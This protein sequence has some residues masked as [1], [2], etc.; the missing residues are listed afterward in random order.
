MI[1][2]KSILFLLLFTI[3]FNSAFSADTTKIA[4]AT[5]TET[6]PKIDGVMDEIWN[7]AKPI[8]DFIQFTPLYNVPTTQKTEVRVLYDDKAIYV[9]ANLFDSSPDSILEQLGSRDDEDL[10]ADYF[11][12][13]F[14]TYNNQLDGY[15]FVVYASGVQA[16][17]R[18]F[19]NTYNAVWES[20]AKITSEG[21]VAE[22][23]IPYSALRFPALEIQTW[24]FELTRNIRRNRETDFWALQVKGAPNDLVYWGKLNGLQN[25]KAPMRLSFNPYISFGIEN[26]KFDSWKNSVNSKSFTGGLDLKY[27]INE[28]FTLDMTLMPDYSQVQSDNKVKNLT[29]FETVY[30][31]QR[32]FFNEAVDLFSKGDLFYS[33]R[34]GKTPTEFY[35]VEFMIDSNETIKKNPSQAQLI[36]STKLSGRNKKGLAIGFFNAI[37]ND[38]WATIIKTDG[39]TRRIL[40]E[41]WANYNILVLDQ[42]LKNNSSVFV[43][44]SNFYRNKNF[45]NSNVTAL[46]LSLYDKTNTWSLKTSGGYSQ[47]YYRGAIPVNSN[48]PVPGIKYSINA[49][50]VNGIFQFGMNHSLIDKNY[51]ANDVGITLL[52]ND[53]SNGLWASYNIY[54]PF[55]IMRQF[56]NNLSIWNSIYFSENKISDLG[57]NY[58]SWGTFKNYLSVWTNFYSSLYDGYDFYEPRVNG[59]YFRKKKSQ[60]AT[61]GFSSDYRKY[62]ALDG[63][64]SYFQTP[65]F[66]EQFRN[67][68]LTPIV[69]ISDHLIVKY[70]L[71]YSFNHNEKGWAGA[72]IQ[73]TIIFGNRLVTTITN[74]FTGKYIIINDLSL[75]INIRHYWS[76]GIY[77]QYY[78]LLDDGNLA[79]LNNDYR[80]SF[81][82]NAFNIDFVCSW[83]FAPGSNLSFVWKKEILNESDIIINNFKENFTNTF[84]QP[85][86]N[87]FSIKA[88]YYIDYQY[89]Q[90]KKK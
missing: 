30:N 12:V 33:R 62:F 25:I 40:T 19:D 78:Q 1:S 44:N 5:R 79:E 36:N 80:Q 86:W 56:H 58:N 17:R 22:Y 29:A 81:N 7:K 10:N 21:W 15:T 39:S 35:N 75:S 90:K 34:I 13:E 9:F 89:L 76:K 51:N 66:N 73:D 8:S 28:S 72:N 4:F 48:V 83:Q 70:S 74:T 26:Y 31:E 59:R 60:G 24:G 3:C 88:I 50:K 38:T 85:Q 47:F 41:P 23:K 82:Y 64:L 61:I 55:W 71:S 14:D 87:T 6:P 63:E 42:A 16:D 45:Y 57:F 49:G 53:M 68:T 32:P 46:G 11:E 52:N 69:R 67:F 27:G 18:E 37:T 77:N 2:Y 65:G 54:E 20:K 84:E 43:S